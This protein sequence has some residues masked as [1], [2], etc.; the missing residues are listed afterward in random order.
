MR[1]QFTMGLHGISKTSKNDFCWPRLRPWPSQPGLP[2]DLPEIAS[3]GRCQAADRL[4]AREAASDAPESAA[5]GH[6]DLDIL[7]MGATEPPDRAHFFL[8]AMH[9]GGKFKGLTRTKQIIEGFRC[10]GTLFE[11]HQLWAYREN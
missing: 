6:C 9:F 3:E 5:A 8:N 1:N 7:D 2:A 11:P 10:F 4:R